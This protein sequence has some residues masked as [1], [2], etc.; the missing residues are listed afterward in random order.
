MVLE[1]H[2]PSI[3]HPSATSAW[4][5]QPQDDGSHST[6]SEGTPQGA[7]QAERELPSPQ[8]HLL[9]SNWTETAPC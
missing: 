9:C 3:S 4:H 6:H 2:L 7:L 5:R 8:S 1:L